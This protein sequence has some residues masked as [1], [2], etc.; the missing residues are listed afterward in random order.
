MNFNTKCPLYSL[1]VRSV[2]MT[3]IKMHCPTT[4]RSCRMLYVNKQKMPLALCTEKKPW[5]KKVFILLFFSFHRK[6]EGI[7]FGNAG[8]HLCHGLSY[9][10]AGGAKRFNPDGYEKDHAIIPHGL[11]VVI[12]AP[13]V[14]DFTGRYFINSKFRNCLNLPK[15]QVLLHKKTPSLFFMWR[16]FPLSICT[17]VCNSPI[18]T[19][20]FDEFDF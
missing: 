7:G 3:P 13:A 9:S 15:S 10:I 18:W 11:S 20:L 6:I 17:L 1:K 4:S 2:W 12:T 16:T 19:I 14:F 8:V 5:E